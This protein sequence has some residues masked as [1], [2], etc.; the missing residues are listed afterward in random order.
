M[1][2]PNTPDVPPH[3]DGVPP[4]PDAVPV[5]KAA[6]DERGPLDDP[7]A[8]TAKR[9]REA[10]GWGYLWYRLRGSPLTLVGFGL[11]VLYLFVAAAAP[12]LAPTPDDWRSPYDVKPRFSQQL[13]EPNDARCDPACPST[14]ASSGAR[15]SASPWASP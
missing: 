1:V 10:R 8:N 6:R 11:I 9:A 4:V 13:L 7:R 15:A 2:M 3:A 14:T 12:L 5:P